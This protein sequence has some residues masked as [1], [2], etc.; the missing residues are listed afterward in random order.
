MG[1]GDQAAN[2]AATFS[3]VLDYADPAKP[4]LYTFLD[5]VLMRLDDTLGAS[6]PLY[7]MAL[8]TNDGFSGSKWGGAKMRYGN[9][10][11]SPFKFCAP[12]PSDKGILSSVELAHG[13]AVGGGSAK[14]QGM[15]SGVVR[16]AGATCLQAELCNQAT[17]VSGHESVSLFKHIVLCDSELILGDFFLVLV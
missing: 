15:E 13:A 14:L 6:A 1:T 11:G 8:S 3:F 9:E 7:P 5:G 10:A 4:H 17:G 12:V 2:L 16:L